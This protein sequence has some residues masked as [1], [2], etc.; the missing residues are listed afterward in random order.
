MQRLLPAL[1][2]IL[3]AGYSSSAQR[4][5]ATHEYLQ[6]ELKTNPSLERKLSIIESFISTKKQVS[7]E[8]INSITGEGAELS[9]IKIPVVFHIVYNTTEQNI[10]DAQIQ[11][12]I[13]AL[14][15]DYRMLN[16]D[17]V[18]TPAVFKHLAADCRIGFYLATVDPHGYATNGIIRKKTGIQYF[19]LDDRIKSSAI[20]GDDPWNADN[21]LNIWVGNMAGG[22]LG[23]ANPLGG[24]KEKDGVVLH[25]LA[26]GTLGTVRPPYNKGRTATH[27]VGHWLGLRHI[28]G[29]QYCG[30]DF[31][32]DTP[33]QRSPGYG[34]PTGV[35]I[36]CDNGPNGNMYMNYMDLSNDP[37]INLFTV[38]QRDRMR[39]LFEPGG[40]HHALLSSNGLGTPLPKPAEAPIDTSVAVQEAVHVYPNPAYNYLSVDITKDEQLAGKLL[41]VYTPQGQIVTQARITS[42]VM[43]LYVFNLKAGIYILRI[44]GQKKAWKVIKR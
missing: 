29:D 11:S 19:G 17:T 43:Q 35:I 41:T 25:H 30:N 10:S 15:R 34:C 7:N 37:C 20:G 6:Q 31:V 36:T 24:P 16:D 27:E 3:L 33:N 2:L 40:I 44:E 12:Q 18:N 26:A 1:V 4:V 32:D 13:D 39:K 21:Y 23:Y 5:C 9:V 38:G 14:N 28:W 42:T 8:I 22:L